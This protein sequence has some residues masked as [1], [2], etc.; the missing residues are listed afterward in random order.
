[1]SQG[2]GLEP[3]ITQRLINA[4]FLQAGGIV[5]G[6]ARMLNIPV[7]TASRLVRGEVAAFAPGTVARIAEGLAKMGAGERERLLIIE[8]LLVPN[9]FGPNPEAHENRLLV[10][11][12][13][14]PNFLEER[15][16]RA[17]EQLAITGET[18]VKFAAEGRYPPPE[19]ESE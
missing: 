12:I 10:Q 7:G 15:I 8:G 13:L 5:R 6:V 3:V 14:Y 17:R 4:A 19:E 9:P 18:A 1:M 2:G 16:G 11:Y